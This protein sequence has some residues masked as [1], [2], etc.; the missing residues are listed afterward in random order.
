MPTDKKLLALVY[1]G[2][3]PTGISVMTF[4][5]YKRVDVLPQLPYMFND[6]DRR[7]PEAFNYYE[8]IGQSLHLVPLVEGQEDLLPEPPKDTRLIKPA[9]TEFTKAL[10]DAKA[11]E[12]IRQNLE[13]GKP[14]VVAETEPTTE[15]T[16]DPTTDEVDR[17][18]NHVVTDVNPNVHTT[19]IL[20]DGENP[21]LST[22]EE[23]LTQVD[24]LCKDLAQ[25]LIDNK[26]TMESITDEELAQLLEPVSTSD[27]LK[28]LGRALNVE[29]SNARKVSKL[30]GEFIAND[31]AEFTN[32]INRYIE[33]LSTPVSE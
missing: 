4:K 16:T 2:A 3:R 17:E 23:F 6:T 20:T 8:R 26:L 32:L 1:T 11:E 28:C 24:V 33:V 10:E 30:V 19:G 14:P 27:A 21:L 5:S 31:K 13:N 9:L 12:I 15:S 18:P 7:D 29:L 25:Q 22:D